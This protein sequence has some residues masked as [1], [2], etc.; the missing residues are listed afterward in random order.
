MKRPT[1]FQLNLL[2]QFPRDES[3]ILWLFLKGNGGRA[4]TRERI[5][6]LQLKGYIEEHTTQSWRFRL[7]DETIEYL[8]G[9]KIK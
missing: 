6:L 8:N 1:V 5:Q 3:Y 2:M 9:V 7:T 4:M